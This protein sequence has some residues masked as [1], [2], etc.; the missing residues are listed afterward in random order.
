MALR[1]RLAADE[2]HDEDNDLAKVYRERLLE[3][4]ALVRDRGW[5]VADE[6]LAPGVRSIAAPVLGEAGRVQ[7]TVN[8]TVHAAETPLGTLTG[9]YLP[10]LLRT[11]AA[12]SAS[13]TV[14]TAS[15]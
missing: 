10:H 15:R 2:R 13:D 12:I 8:I 4:L 5:A 6:E 7:S 14:T 11:A 3:E 9:E 1:D